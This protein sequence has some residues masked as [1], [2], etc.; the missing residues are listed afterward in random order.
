[1]SDRPVMAS[2]LQSVAEELR[3]ARNLLGTDGC[4]AL[5][6]VANALER[7]SMAKAPTPPVETAAGAAKWNEAGSLPSDEREVL[8][9]LNGHVG[10]H[11]A[12]GRNGGGWGL[13]LGW[14]DNDRRFWRVG[15]QSESHVTHWMDEP[16]APPLLTSTPTAPP[17]DAGAR[18]CPKC[19]GKLEEPESLA[20]DLCR[21]CRSQMAGGP[22]A[23]NENGAEG[24]VPCPH[25]DPSCMGWSA[26]GGGNCAVLCAACRVDGEVSVY[27]DRLTT[28]IDEEF[29][30]Q[31]VEPSMMALLDSLERLL[32]ERRRAA[33]LAPIATP[34]AERD[35]AS[36]WPHIPDRTVGR[37]LAMTE[38]MGN[39]TQCNKPKGHDGMH[40]DG[41]IEFV[42]D[43]NGAPA[44]EET[45]PEKIPRCPVFLVTSDGATWNAKFG[46]DARDRSLRFAPMVPRALLAVAEKERD[47]YL[48]TVGQWK[49]SHGRA[50]AERDT[51]QRSAEWAQG[52]CERLRAL[53]R[54]NDAERDAI[55]AERDE[56]VALLRSAAPRVGHGAP[57]QPFAECGGTPPRFDAHC[58]RCQIDAA[59]SRPA[60][61]GGAR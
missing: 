15:G 10:I 58:A 32:F 18:H 22:M 56:A 26:L 25:R 43:R 37:C 6:H 36:S 46:E 60:T 35:G 1:M 33:Q 13:R 61:S 24:G 53:V 34:A 29:G 38:D 45:D 21:P 4:A 9:F 41:C 16:L 54:G 55:R 12:D 27:R 17:A 5:V 3:G 44:V 59:L 19:G 2:E 51:A 47:A 8:V 40:S 48:R 11:D 31:P 14:F 30:L 20:A 52:E 49:D 23:R 7:V 42:R 50:L 28:I 39:P 57:G